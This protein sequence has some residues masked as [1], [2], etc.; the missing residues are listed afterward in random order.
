MRK[1]LSEMVQQR[2]RSEVSK[3]AIGISEGW[4]RAE[5]R[6]LAV[7]GEEWSRTRGRRSWRTLETGE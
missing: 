1:G 7:L 5:P 3:S 4:A 2:D 6:M